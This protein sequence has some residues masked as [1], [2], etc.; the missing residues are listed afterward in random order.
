MKRKDGVIANNSEKSIGKVFL[1]INEEG[2]MGV[3]VVDF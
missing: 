3:N 1:N 2:R